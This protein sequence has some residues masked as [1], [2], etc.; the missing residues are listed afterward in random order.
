MRSI[1]LEIW[2]IPIVYVFWNAR[3]KKIT[4]IN[5]SGLRSYSSDSNSLGGF[6]EVSI[7]LLC[8][9]NKHKNFQEVGIQIH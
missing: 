1:T 8:S 9:L 7:N 6:E 5:K 4:S 2:L 3:V